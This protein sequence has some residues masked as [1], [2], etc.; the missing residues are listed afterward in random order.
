LTY[1]SFVLE[2]SR[3]LDEAILAQIPAAIVVFRASDQVIVYAND[4]ALQVSGY[5]SS[6]F[7][8]VSLWD[9]LVEE[10]AKR[11]LDEAKK[12]HNKR[13]TENSDQ[14]EGF[15]RILTKSRT[16]LNAWFTVKDIVDADG[17]VR[18]RTI[19]GFVNYDKQADDDH[20][21]AK[22][23]SIVELG[24]RRS[25]GLV[26]SE[27]NNA[28]AVLQFA[29]ETRGLLPGDKS[30]DNALAPLKSIGERLRRYGSSLEASNDQ[31]MPTDDAANTTLHPKAVAALLFPKVLVVDDDFKLLEA[32]QELLFMNGVSAVIAVSTKMALEYA[33]L[34][35]PE[36]ALIDL[37]LGTE[38]GRDAAKLL[39]ESFPSMKIIFMT[40]YA[41]SLHSIENEGKFPVLK[42]PFQIDSLISHLRNKVSV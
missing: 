21:R 12:P 3:P 23:I 15:V 5:S 27:V 39:L 13:A 32:L 4:V 24:L 20:Q 19:L 9:L 38:D 36:V 42:K 2:I 8:K 33:H 30:L 37:R 41:D 17:L 18:F 28:L 25:A 7:G 40:G 10:D 11:A 16:E 29:L 1:D 35:L 22:L 26:A 34:F 6:D 31:D 14:S